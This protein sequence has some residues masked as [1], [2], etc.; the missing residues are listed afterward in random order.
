MY[1]LPLGSCDPSRVGFLQG[2]FFSL[3]SKVPLSIEMPTHTL[4]HPP[5]LQNLGPQLYQA[6]PLSP[7]AH[8]SVLGLCSLEREQL[9]TA[10]ISVVSV[11]LCQGHLLECPSPLT[12][13]SNLQ[14]GALAPLSTLA[15][16]YPHP[17]RV[18]PP[19]Q[20]GI[21]ADPITQ[22]SALCSYI[23]PPPAG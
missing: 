22:L 8:C 7:R 4:L 19:W 14:L 21:N 20:T 5:H 10:C 9:F 15:L 2:V 17:C 6:Y 13:A 23:K 12:L 18:H 3:A 16:S 1:F 11:D